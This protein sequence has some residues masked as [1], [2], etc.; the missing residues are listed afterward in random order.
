MPQSCRS[1][2][3]HEKKLPFKRY[4]YKN[5]FTSCQD[6]QNLPP[7]PIHHSGVTLCVYYRIYFY[8]IRQKERKYYSRKTEL[9]SH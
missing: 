4:S 5:K 3:F 6:L 7:H 2:E 9:S 1:R 8:N